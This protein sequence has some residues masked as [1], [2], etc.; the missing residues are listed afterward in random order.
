MNV[1]TWNV[2][3]THYMKHIWNDSQAGQSPKDEASAERSFRDLRQGRLFALF[4]GRFQVSSDT[5]EWQR[6]S[7]GTD[8]EIPCTIYHVLYTIYYQLYTLQNILTLMILK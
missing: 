7:S 3:N 2:L 1:V 8:V 4:R 5:L 6:S